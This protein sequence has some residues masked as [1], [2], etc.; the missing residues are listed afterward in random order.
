VKQTTKAI[1]VLQLREYATV[2]KQLLGSGPHATMKILSE[3]VF[4]M[5]SAPRLYHST[6]RVQL[7]KRSGV[8]RI[9]W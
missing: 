6:G 7:V 3:V 9:G 5:W 1:A 2:L 8:E 4:F